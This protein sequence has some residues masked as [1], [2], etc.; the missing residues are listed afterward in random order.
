MLGYLF[1]AKIRAILYNLV[2]HKGMAIIIL[3]IG[4]FTKDTAI[5][6]AALILYSHSSMDRIMG[7]GLKYPDSFK[8]THLGTLG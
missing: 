1:S 8:N 2:H 6:A 4:Y 5:T 7:Y 3:G